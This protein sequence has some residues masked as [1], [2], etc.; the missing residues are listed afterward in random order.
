MGWNSGLA[1]A[2]VCA[3]V[4]VGGTCLRTPEPTL[5]LVAIDGADFKVLKDGEV[6]LD[7][8]LAGWGP[9]WSWSAWEATTSPTPNGSRLSGTMKL[10]TGATLTLTGSLGST[11]ARTAVL[12]VAVASDRDTDLTSLILAIELSEVFHGGSVQPHGRNPV[13]IPFGREDFGAAVSR[14]SL[15]DRNGRLVEIHMDPPSNLSADG[16]LRAI[17]VQN[18]LAAGQGVRRRITFH[19]PESVRLIADRGEVPAE[20]GAERWFPLQVGLPGEGRDERSLADWFETPAGRRGRISMDG[21]HL[22]YGGERIK[23]WGLNLSFADCAPPKDLA[24]RRAEF[25][26]RMGINAVRLHKYADGPGWAGIQSTEKFAEFDAA[27][28]DRMDYFVAQLKSKGIFV[29]LSPTFMVKLGHGDREYVPYLDEFGQLGNARDARVDTRHGSIYL[30]RELQDLQIRQTLNLLRHRN[31]YTG[32]TYAEDPAIAIV[33]MFNEDSALFFGT[34]ARLQEVP[35]LRRRAAAQF[36]QWLRRKYGTEARLL[37]AWGP[38]SLNAFAGEGF[39]GESWDANTIVP[40]GNPWFFDP[41][42][43]EGSQRARA[44]RL[45]DTMLFLYELQNDFYR[46][47]ER[48]LRDAG[49]PGV[50]ISSNWIAGRSFSHFYNLDSD[51]QIVLVDRHNYFGGSRGSTIADRSMLSRP[52]S[53]MLSTGM[54]QVAGRPFSLS[55]WIHVFP[56]EWGAE[57]PAILGAYGMGLQGWDVSFIF[58]NRDQGTFSDRIGRDLW[59]AVAPQVI[60]LFPAVSRQVL[61]GDVSES[62][63]VIPRNVHVPSMA[64][65]RIGFDDRVAAAGDIKETDS[66][67]VPIEALAIGRNVVRFTDQ[68]EATPLFDVNRCIRDGVATSSTGQLRW[69]TGDG[70]QSG[71]IQIDTP[72]TQAVVGFAE[73]RRVS[74]GDVEIVPRS[75]FAAI[76][77]TA[78]GRDEALAS[79]RAVLLTAIARAR[80]TGMKIFGQVLLDRGQPPILMEPVEAS[81]T[82]KRQGATVHI[83]DHD[84]RRTGRTVPVQNGV[85][86]I[87]TGRDR[88]CWYLVTFP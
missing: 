54:N 45:H 47:F 17:I 81:I 61:R 13:A 43:L 33:E 88:T 53:G 26:A 77:A 14:V 58:Q 50:L 57:G 5:T 46:R 86:Q 27:A 59:D 8:G 12:D 49:Y 72:G 55:E 31:P 11:G 69:Q 16:A 24:D 63:L 83:L 34:M 37:E 76:Y 52:G 9:N 74:M 2:S 18:R 40:V 1:V 85:V 82:F 51:R 39:T 15:R 3:L 70:R 41:D 30:S 56:N 22:V 65:G 75:R 66:R 36:T 42:Q 29:K 28:L 68:F 84:G 21:D 35:T 78:R 48:A 6:Y 67:T 62:D 20:P 60:G 44:R 10:G 71:W 25:Y 38:N 79:G 64:E 4:G 87:D 7:L 19:F 23:L 32:L 73:G 80:N